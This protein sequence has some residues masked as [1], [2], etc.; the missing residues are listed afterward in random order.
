[1]NQNELY[2]SVAK[3]AKRFENNKRQEFILFY[4]FIKLQTYAILT[5][6]LNG[7]EQNQF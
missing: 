3:T 1:M 5:T 4:F 2:D 6:F 7:Q